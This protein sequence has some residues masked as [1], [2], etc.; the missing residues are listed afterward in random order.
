MGTNTWKSNDAGCELHSKRCNTFRCTYRSDSCTVRA[1][2]EQ[3]LSLNTMALLVS[4]VVLRFCTSPN[5]CSSVVG[6]SGYFNTKALQECG[7]GTDE[8]VTNG[9]ATPTAARRVLCNRGSISLC[10]NG[11]QTIT[12]STTSR[13]IHE[14]VSF[15]QPSQA[16]ILQFANSCFSCNVLDNY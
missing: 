14:R 7:S 13:S 10:F 16:N 11:M 15:E 9:S 5:Q 2:C 4:K 3:E 6:I 8:D 1:K 12:A